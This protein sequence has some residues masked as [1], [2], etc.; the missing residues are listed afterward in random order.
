ML[1][2]KNCRLV[3]ELTEDYEDE[4]AD[5]TIENRI[6][7]GI[8]KPGMPLKETVQIWRGGRFCPDYLICI[9]I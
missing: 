2:L 1:I 3:A 5:I 6:I 9:C 4:Y 7:S 8:Y